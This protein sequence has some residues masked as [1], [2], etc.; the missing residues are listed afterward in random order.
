[1]ISKKW[2]AD[3][4]L[5]NTADTAASEAAS[6]KSAYASVSNPGVAMGRVDVLAR[7]A[8]SRSG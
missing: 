7:I 8:E 2:V 4:Q 6:I 5:F 3:S 1:M